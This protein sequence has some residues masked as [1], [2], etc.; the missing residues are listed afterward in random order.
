MTTSV[1][2]QAVADHLAF[3]IRGYR[4]GM[5]SPTDIANVATEVERVVKALT[6]TGHTVFRSGETPKDL[7]DR[8]DEFLASRH[9][10]LWGTAFEIHSPNGR[11]AAAEWFASQIARLFGESGP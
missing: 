1:D 6:A 2:L 4:R 3:A 11:R 7:V 9:C 10:V 8:C 5:T